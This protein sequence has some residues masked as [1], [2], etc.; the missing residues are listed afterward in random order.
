MRSYRFGTSMLVTGLYYA[1]MCVPKES[2]LRRT[3]NGVCKA[4]VASSLS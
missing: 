3:A 4:G 1:L 2:L